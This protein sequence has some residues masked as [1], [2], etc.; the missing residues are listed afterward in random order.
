MR[1]LQGIFY[2]FVTDPPCISIFPSYLCT[3]HMPSAPSALYFPKVPTASL[4]C[5]TVH[6]IGWIPQPRLSLSLRLSLGMSGWQLSLGLSDP[7][8]SSADWRGSSLARRPPTLGMLT[9]HR[10]HGGTCGMILLRW[11]LFAGTSHRSSCVDLS[12]D[13]PGLPPF[14]APLFALLQRRS[15]T[16]SSHICQL[17]S[18]LKIFWRRS[19]DV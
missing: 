14:I 3:H 7:S 10:A 9:S 17:N 1:Q 12:V 6:A 5:Q 18:C 2:I 11:R 8:T 15:Y 4:P 13:S 19:F 16:C